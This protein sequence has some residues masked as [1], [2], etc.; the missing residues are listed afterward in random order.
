MVA[1]MTSWLRASILALAALLVASTA[2]GLDLIVDST[3]DTCD[4]VPGDS[5]CDDGGG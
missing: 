3:A 4:A 5:L 1:Q 2:S